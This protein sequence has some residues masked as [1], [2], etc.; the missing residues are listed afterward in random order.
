MTKDPSKRL[1]NRRTEIME[2]LFFRH[3]DWEKLER[4]EI[5][6]PYRP[7]IVRPINSFSPWYFSY[8]MC[9]RETTCF[10]ISHLNI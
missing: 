7:V 1:G 8:S 6:P 5:Q 9:H 4:L 3:I 10:W 2:H